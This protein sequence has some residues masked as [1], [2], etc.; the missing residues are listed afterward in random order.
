[1]PRMI[2]IHVIDPDLRNDPEIRGFVMEMHQQFESY[3]ERYMEDV[4]ANDV[5]S[6]RASMHVVPTPKEK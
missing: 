6:R 2:R 4:I 5:A 1:M 3:A